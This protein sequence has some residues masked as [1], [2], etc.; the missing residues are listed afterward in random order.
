LLIL[1]YIIRYSRYES[2]RKNDKKQRMGWRSQRCGQTAGTHENH[3]LR[4]S[5]R[6]SSEEGDYPMEA[7]NLT[8]GGKVARPL[9]FKRCFIGDESVKKTLTK[10]LK[11]GA[12]SVTL[13]FDGAV[14]TPDTFRR[15]VSAFV[16]L[17]NAVTEKAAGTGK[18]AVWNMAVAKGSRLLIAT[19][20]AD[21]KTEVVAEKVIHAIPDGLRRLEKGT[22]VS[23]TYFDQRALR[24]ARE[25]AS[26]PKERKLTYVKFWAAGPP[27]P[28]SQRSADTAVKLLG[29]HQALGS[30]EG[31]LQT[32]SE[33]GTLQFV[34]F[35][36]LYDKGINCFMDEEIMEQAMQAFRKR[37]AVTGMVQYDQESRPVSIRVDTIQVFKDVAELPPIKDLRGI[38]KKAQ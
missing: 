32:I 4:F 20:V 38:F 10:K 31:K 37:V 21:R 18:R 16:D 23:P 35:D 17:L 25:L 9:W 24:A 11:K 8:V 3:S 36:S 29:Q 34:V 5:E 1:I 27:V 22:P 33:R 7:T 14:V 30:V 2:T 13:D 15:L 28:V 26:I 19:A 12:N 6:D